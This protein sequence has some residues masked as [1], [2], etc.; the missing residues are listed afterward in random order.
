[1]IERIKILINQKA[2][3]VREFAS[4][5]GVAQV[6]LNQQITAKRSI[7]LETTQAIL[8]SFEDISAEWLMRGIGPMIRQEHT[9]E[10]PRIESMKTEI[11]L[12]RGENRVL[13]EQL[14]LP[15]RKET[16]TLSA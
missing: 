2:K 4:I 10:D 13:R 6:T 12:L 3:S 11:N 15:E 14:G 8:N 9:T 7:S 5:I 16:A 1:M